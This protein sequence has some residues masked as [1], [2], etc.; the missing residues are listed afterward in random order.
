MDKQLSDVD[1]GYMVLNEEYRI[2]YAND[3]FQNLVG[4]DYDSKGLIG[5]RFDIFLPPSGSLFFHLHF[6]TLILMNGK[7]ENMKID[8]KSISG[9]EFITIPIRINAEKR[10]QDGKVLYDCFIVVE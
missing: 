9:T 3:A 4:S 8:I 6:H 5:C 1:N 7:V 2:V 10:V